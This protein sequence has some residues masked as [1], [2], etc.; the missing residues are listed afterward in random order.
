MLRIEPNKKLSELL[1]KNHKSVFKV[2][3]RNHLHSIE[4]VKKDENQSEKRN[5]KTNN[6]R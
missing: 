1:M 6:N 3:Y 5:R 2:K 4:E